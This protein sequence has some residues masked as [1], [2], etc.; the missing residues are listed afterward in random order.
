MSIDAINFAWNIQGVSRSERLLL[1]SLADH[2][3]E[4]DLCW[5]SVKRLAEKALMSERLVQIT[6]R[7]LEAKNILATDPMR[8]PKG[9]N[10][11]YL[12]GHAT[13][14]IYCG[15]AWEVMDHFIPTA[16][17][18]SD[19]PSNMVPACDRCNSA[20]GAQ[21]PADFAPAVFAGR[22]NGQEGVNPTAPEPL[23]EPSSS[24]TSEATSIPRSI[25]W[26]RPSWLA[27]L[28][29]GHVILVR[30]EAR[31]LLLEQWVKREGFTDEVL[32]RAADDLCQAWPDIKSK[33]DPRKR[34]MNWCRRAREG[35]DG[36]SRKDRQGHSK[37]LPGDR[38][39]DDYPNALSGAGAQLFSVP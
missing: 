17:G 31:D 14:C 30:D 4:Q 21:H 15:G 7:K 27:T 36:R 25:I 29:E 18:G 19:D 16:L 22:R 34:Y 24:T 11:Y 2:A 1:L 5:P 38:E 32:Q 35:N 23:R 6:L 39:F 28:Y 9:T 3:N 37:G 8:G 13:R 26:P 20:K 33:K 10:M 12:V